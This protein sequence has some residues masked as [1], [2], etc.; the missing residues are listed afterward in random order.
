[1]G[2]LGGTEITGG[3]RQ[4]SL[5]YY[6]A[7]VG[8]TA[9]QTKEADLFN[10]VLAQ[11]DEA[12][13][14]DPAA[15]REACAAGH[16]LVQA[17][18]EIVRRRNKIQ[19]VPEAA[20][21]L[22]WAWYITTLTYAAWAQA[23][24]SAMKALVNSGTPHYKYVQHL[25]GEHE[26]ALRKAQ[27]EE[28]K[29]LKRLRIPADDIQTIEDRSMEAAETDGWKPELPSNPDHTDAPSEMTVHVFP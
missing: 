22:H 4:R 6:E 15:A 27:K 7:E 1:M 12:I 2:L 18:R 24:L 21:S 28:K 8:V 16:R 13:A 20:F 23:T 5:A 17:A 14:K 19:P 25:A 9:F 11:H 10:E 29:F 3:E 26:T